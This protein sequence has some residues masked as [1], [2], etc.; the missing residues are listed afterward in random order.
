MSEETTQISSDNSPDAKKESTWRYATFILAA[1]LIVAAFVF[2]TKGP[3]GNAV[4]NGETSDMSSFISNTK[5]YPS[6]GPENA[7]VVVVEFSDFQCPFCALASGLPAFAKQ[8]S[9][10]YGDLIGSAEKIKKL[11]QDGKIK[12]VYVPMNFLGDESTYATEAAL[13]ANEQGKFW[14]MYSLLFSSHDGQENNGKYSKDNLKT[15][16][17]KIQGIDSKKFNECIDSG[18][19]ESDAKSIN[20][21]ANA[22]G[23]KGTPVFFVN[24]EKT[25][26]SWIELSGKLKAAGVNLN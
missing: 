22:V 7:Q 24:G 12:F 11:A 5:L 15:F 8:Y 25:S 21:N 13:C 16:A 19:Y 20:K 3:T 9:N 1:V 23:V 17:Q 6:I 4:N 2:F 10:Q 14:E 18:K 26:A